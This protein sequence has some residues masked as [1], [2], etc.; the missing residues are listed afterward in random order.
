MNN[1]GIYAKHTK[2]EDGASFSS[3]N[4]EVGITGKLS[5]NVSFEIGSR[6]TKGGERNTIASVSYS[7][8]LGSSKI[9]ND[10]VGTI[11]KNLAR[12]SIRNKLYIPVER[13]N[14]IIKKA[15]GSVIVKGY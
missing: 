6:K 7:V 13:E 11:D 5:K 8:P 10:H 4:N 9:S 14:R 12:P 1:T 15:V 2:W 3:E